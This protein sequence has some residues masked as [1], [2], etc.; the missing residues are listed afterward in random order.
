MNPN[1][2][3]SDNLERFRL[4]VDCARDYAIFVTDTT[5]GI[6][7][8][9]PGVREI[10]GYE[11]AEFVGSNCARIFTPEDR[12]RGADRQERD[13]AR[14]EGRA[15]DERWHVRKDGSRFWASGVMTALHD[16]TGNL[17]GFSKILRDFT[18]QKETQDALQRAHERTS[19]ILES[20]SDAFYAVDGSFRFTYVNRKAEEWWGRSREALVGKHYWT[21][22]PQAV[23]SEPYHMHLRAMAERVP[24]HFEAVSP[25]IGRWVDINIYPAEDGGLAVYFRDITERKRAEEA[26]RARTEEL[27]LAYTREKYIAE[28]LQRPLTMPVAGDTFPGLL[29]ATYYEAALE[30]AKVGGDYFDAFALPRGRVALVVADAS[31]KGL[32]AAARAIQVKEVLRAFTREYPHSPTHI[33]SRLND[34][35]CDTKHFEE[36]PEEGFVTLTLAVL[37]AHTGEMS[38]VNAGAEPPLVLRKDGRTETVDVSGLPLGVLREELYH[39]FPLRLAPGDTLL[40]ATDGL[41]EARRGDAFLG[42]EGLVDLATRADV[43][44]PPQ[45]IVEQVVEGA[46]AFAAGGFRDDVCLLL[47]RRL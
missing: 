40:L 30:E 15:M 7:T 41:T 19:V 18:R 8:W 22:F 14:A 43:A 33:L 3:P 27:Q 20:I 6:T 29:L 21:E 38:V 2:L 45:A 16:E 4:V 26:L 11:E 28:A 23:G 10:L 35:V 37:D 17:V 42:L 9:N 13:T 39:A 24:L 31:G 47:A 12:E 5:G 44:S 25:L 46:R 1:P 32:Q 36:Q 34:Y